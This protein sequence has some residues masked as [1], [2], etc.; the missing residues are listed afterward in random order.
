MALRGLRTLGVR[1]RRHQESALAVASWL[2]N[3]PEVHR[4]D[5]PGYGIWQR[6]FLGASGL[7]GFTLK[8]YSDRHSLRSSITWTFSSSATAGVDTKA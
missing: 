4:V 5:D 1:M 3:R 7:F 6:D 2:K 8:S